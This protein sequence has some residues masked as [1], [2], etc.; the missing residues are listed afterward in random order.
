LPYDDVLGEPQ[1]QSPVLIPTPELLVV[2]SVAPVVVAV[3]AVV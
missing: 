1:S 2:V 3:A